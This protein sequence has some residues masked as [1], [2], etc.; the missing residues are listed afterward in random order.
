MLHLSF[1]L[2]D[3]FCCPPISSAANTIQ[4]RFPSLPHFS[5]FCAT[6][7]SFWF[8]F[9]SCSAGQMELTRAVE[10]GWSRS[11]IDGCL[12]R[13]V[14]VRSG[15][16]LSGLTSIFFGFRIPFLIIIAHVRAH[17]PKYSTIMTYY[18]REHDCSSRF[19]C[20]FR[21][22]F[23]EFSWGIGSGPKGAATAFQV[24]M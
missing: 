18:K 16:K 13:G 4:A 17:S 6:Q 10:A 22:A 8:I 1:R 21:Q 19:S 5:L 24:G 14:C 12:C 7:A 2:A 11:L 9:D 3:S 20:V 15:A 23:D